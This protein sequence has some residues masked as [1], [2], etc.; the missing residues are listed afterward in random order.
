MIK[1]K[2]SEFAP[3][4]KSAAFN[5]SRRNT[6]KS[7]AAISAGVALPKLAAGDV[8]SQDSPS[9]NALTQKTL[10][11]RAAQYYFEVAYPGGYPCTVHFKN[12]NRATGPAP[13]PEQVLTLPSAPGTS[14]GV[15]PIAFGRLAYGLNSESTEEIVLYVELYGD[16][17]AYGY[18]EVGGSKTPTFGRSEG[19]FIAG[20]PGNDISLELYDRSAELP[21]LA[22]T[23]A[24]TST[25]FWEY[26]FLVY[27]ELVCVVRL[28]N[29]SSDPSDID[30]TLATNP[31]P[32]RAITYTYEISSTSTDGRKLL[33]PDAFGSN[34]LN[35]A[36]NRTLA[37]VIPDPT[38]GGINDTL[39]LPLDKA[40][41]DIS[42]ALELMPTQINTE[43]GSNVNKCLK[44]RLIR[45]MAM[46][47]WDL[48]NSDPAGFD[49]ATD[50]T[51]A[52]DA[53]V[54]QSF[55]LIGGN[56]LVTAYQ[57]A[58]NSIRNAINSAFSIGNQGAGA[59]GNI[60]S[61]ESDLIS[62]LEQAV[63]AVMTAE[64]DQRNL[65]EARYGG[66]P[67]MPPA[68]Y[69]AGTGDVSQ[70][71]GGVFAAAYCNAQFQVTGTLGAFPLTLAGVPCVL[72]GGAR[73][74]Y[75]IAQ[76]QSYR[77]L[78]DNG[79][80]DGSHSYSSPTDGSTTGRYI[81]LTLIMSLERVTALLPSWASLDLEVSL[82]FQ[83]KSG[84]WRLNSLQFDPV[85]DVDTRGFWTSVIVEPFLSSFFSSLPTELNI[86]EALEGA[87]S[88]ASEDLAS[89]PALSLV[90]QQ[91]RKS[92]GNA[93]GT[94]GE[95]AGS[96]LTGVAP[97][98]GSYLQ[99]RASNA[100]FDAFLQSVG[101]KTFSTLEVSLFRGLWY[102]SNCAPGQTFQGG[103]NLQ[104]A[105]VWLPGI[106]YI[107]GLG[108][109][110]EWTD[111]SKDSLKLY[112]RVAGTVDFGVMVGSPGAWLYLDNGL[113][114]P[115]GG[116]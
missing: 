23:T 68:Q 51:A 86:T 53:W 7:V 33:T 83:I 49:D 105:F 54:N 84:V 70:S 64:D 88:Q 109:A 17:N 3:T 46:L 47:P 74:S 12:W 85:F 13:T 41:G 55:T 39:A 1:S 37:Q 25:V 56:F 80:F 93:I 40:G 15:F 81:S 50:Q 111:K 48:Q 10:L 18:I 82:N 101:Y 79:Y 69:Q 4:K 44:R 38:A 77:A 20:Q 30:E 90:R 72:K 94:L 8:I 115:G 71:G 100:D 34:F 22:I 106:K 29:S 66:T 76:A 32:S 6:I 89:S 61:G 2:T 31:P 11:P 42:F 65:Q 75:N 35:A 21:D 113:W 108:L 92:L 5:K 36:Q 27:E 73:V 103:A 78:T 52:N 16:N 102:N 14:D 99:N 87:A 95:L 67:V 9:L 28:F 63:A 112:G 110:K 107:N 26:H 58:I 116:I 43:P 59:L 97:T 114:S 98:L 57:E 24:Y 91:F 96:S 60:F 19:G 45:H 62:A 104:G